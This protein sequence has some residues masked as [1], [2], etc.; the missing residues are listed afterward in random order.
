MT[1]QITNVLEYENTDVKPANRILKQ[2]ILTEV[3][4]THRESR[5]DKTEILYIEGNATRTSASSRTSSSSSIGAEGGARKTSSSSNHAHAI[6]GTPSHHLVPLGPEFTPPGA[7]AQLRPSAPPPADDPAIIA[8]KAA[9]KTPPD[10]D[11]ETSDV[12]PTAGGTAPVA[13]PEDDSSDTN[14]EGDLDVAPDAAPV[15]PNDGVDPEVF[16]NNDP[17]AV[18]QQALNQA[19]NIAQILAQNPAQDPALDP[20]Q[21]QPIPAALAAPAQAVQNQN[22]DDEIEMSDDRFVPKP[23]SGRLDENGADWIQYFEQYCTYREYNPERQLALMNVLLT[24]NAHGWLSTLADADKNTIAALIAKFKTRYKPPETIKFKSAKELYSR[25]QKDDETVDEYIEAMRKLGRETDEAQGDNM[26]RYAI[27]N[28]LKPGIATYVTQQEPTTLDDVIKAA[29]VAEMTCHDPMSEM[30]AEIKKL[31]QK[32]DKMNGISAAL[33]DT[34]RTPNRS[35]SPS[36]FNRRVAFS[37]QRDRDRE[38]RSYTPTP[39]Q[40]QQYTPY[41]QSGRQSPYFDQQP[42]AP[43]QEG[44]Y[45]LQYTQPYIQN[46]SPQA[47]QYDQSYGRGTYNQGYSA[48]YSQGGGGRPYRGGAR[49]GGYPARAMRGGGRGYTPGYTSYN[50]PTS[51]AY[52]AVQAGGYYQRSQL[53][54]GGEFCSKCGRA[55]HSNILEC[56]ANTR[57]CNICNRRGHFGAVCRSGNR[58]R[59][60][61]TNGPQRGSSY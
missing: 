22:S 20:A 57:N 14:G 36:G 50:G 9:R 24:G 58:A 43:Q 27:L 56:P 44:Q 3:V 54:S 39:Q 4:K 53:Q 42:A 48:T 11:D 31:T 52:G 17:L 60:G 61:F 49:R 1:S 38:R 55:A 7:Q 41:T 59:A 15:D 5:K 45:T 10:S 6:R 32:W 47:G 25:H 8:Q 29:R 2:S 33:N 40:Q 18:N 16:F 21:D 37:D 35:P 34:N 23:F 46:P 51:P 26:A 19:Q 28:G 13:I 12:D 30:R